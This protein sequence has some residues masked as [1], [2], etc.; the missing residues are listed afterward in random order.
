MN[1][2][3]R[4]D[5]P[6]QALV[7]AAERLAASRP[8]RHRPSPSSVDNCTRANW[9]SE[10]GVPPTEIPDA[11]SY[12]AAESGRLTESLLID[13][14]NESGL[15]RCDPLTEEERELLKPQLKKLSLRGGQ[16]DQLGFIAKEGVEDDLVLVEFKR[17]N[18]RKFMEVSTKKVREG[19]PGIYTQLQVLMVSLGLSRALLFC[20][21]WDRQALTS[22][23][24]KKEKR[25]V[26]LYGEWV[27]VSPIHAQIAGKRAA[28]QGQYIDNETN[29]ARVPRDYDPLSSDWHCSWCDWRTPCLAAEGVKRT[30]GHVG[31]KR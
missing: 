10:T 24:R 1:G 5:N 14:V 13:I 27:D 15:A 17:M 25:P 28:M 19:D 18:V 31:D 11:E 4:T 6:T 9:F 2:P 22:Y 23:N 8:N 26:G 16:Y 3:G 29:P 7:E 21:N 20:A 12:I 30:P